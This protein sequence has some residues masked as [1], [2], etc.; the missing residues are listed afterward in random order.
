MMA[1]L[2][3]GAATSSLGEPSLLFMWF[4]SS[5]T[6]ANCLPGPVS[7]LADP[8]NPA[9]FRP[10]AAKVVVWFGDS[11]G[12]G[13]QG[14][15]NACMQAWPRRLQ[16]WA[17]S[18][19]RPVLAEHFRPTQCPAC[20]HR[21]QA[22]TPSV[23]ACATSTQPSCSRTPWPGCRRSRSRWGGCALGSTGMSRGA[24]RTASESHCS[25]LC[26]PCCALQVEMRGAH[27]CCACAAL[28]AAFTSADC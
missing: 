23:R 14:R 20:A 18:K 3:K 9:K 10:S 12:G 1:L 25:M 26:T 27:A 28:S 21:V 8:S 24:V 19:G 5:I 11:P 4:T 15:E 22:T 16:L 6:E 13:R 2:D 17:E 7:Q